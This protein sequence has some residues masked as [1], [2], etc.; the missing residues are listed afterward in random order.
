GAGRTGSAGGLMGVRRVAMLAAAVFALHPLN[1]QTVTYISSRSAGLCTLFYLLTLELAVRGHLAWRRRKEPGR[2]GRVWGWG[3]LAALCLALGAMSKA[4]IITFPALLFLFHF[5]FLWAGSFRGWVRRCRLA[6]LAVAAPL[7]GF[8][9]VRFF[10]EGGIL[11]TGK[12]Y[13]STSTYLLTETFVIPFEY[14]RKMLFPIN[15]SIEAPYP[16]VADWSDPFSY[17]GWA[18]LAGYAAAICRL[19]RTQPYLGF[20]LAWMGI[21]LLPT[22]SFV[23]LHDVA[24]EHRTYLPM[25]GL[26]VAVAAAVEWLIQALPARRAPAGGPAPGKPAA[27][28]V[29]AL[30]GT[31]LGLILLALLLVD[32]NRVWKD[33]V[34]LWSD[35]VE[36]APRLVRTY[37]NLGEAYDALGQYAAAAR[38]FEAALRLNPNYTYALNNLG[39]VYGKQGRFARAEAF[40][41]KVIAREETYA[42]AHY[43]LGRALQ[44]LKR[45][46]EALEHYARAVELVPYFE[47]A[48][49]NYAFLAVQLGR[50]EEGTP[51]FR[52]FIAMQPNRARGHFGLGTAFLAQG[53]FEDAEAAFREAARVEPQYL[54]AFVNL[55]MAQLRSGRIDAAIATFQDLLTRSPGIPGVHKNLGLIFAQHKSNPRQAIHHFRESLRLDPNQPEAALLRGTIADLERRLPL[56]GS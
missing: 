50:P 17:L 27:G 11:P 48:L 21:T 49:Y 43:N 32:R 3:A 2:V 53:R 16:I 45:P 56:T 42:P 47:Q 8:I 51:Y 30:S 39:N 37:N 14:F 34:S 25:V 13:L 33:E 41:R 12:T 10:S 44:A 40:F 5:Y 23:P 4:I 28:R 1:T 52:R 18:A 54:P 6:L 24:V 9:L 31:A 38:Q 7:T 46:Q 55:A 22:S 15:L 19:S 36:K 29:W 26:A 35:A 20:G